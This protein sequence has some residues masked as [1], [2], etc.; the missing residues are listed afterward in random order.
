ME[1]LGIRAKEPCSPL[2]AS[3]ITAGIRVL[4]SDSRRCGRR[5]QP[6]PRMGRIY[7]TEFVTFLDRRPDD[8]VITPDSSA[9]PINIR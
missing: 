7:C 5:V 2:S 4:S 3:L 1:P 9:L 8:G 6:P